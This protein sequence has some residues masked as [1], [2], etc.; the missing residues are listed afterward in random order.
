MILLTFKVHL[1]YD[2]PQNFF[3]HVFLILAMRIILFFFL[4][5]ILENENNINWTF[6]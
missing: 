2:I 4:L 6:F 3:K 1:G 5:F